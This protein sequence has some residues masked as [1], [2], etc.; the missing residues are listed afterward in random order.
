M[1]KV[2]VYS[3]DPNPY[4][5]A[6]YSNMHDVRYK[7][8]EAPLHSYTLGIILSFPQLILYR[9][10]GYQIFHLHWLYIFNS[11]IPGLLFNNFFIKLFFMIYFVCFL[12]LIK[13]LGYKLIWTAH[14]LAPHE[15]QFLNDTFAY[16]LVAKLA[17]SII[18]HSEQTR[19]EMKRLGFRTDR[20]NIIPVGNY[21]ELY[22]NNV[23]KS[24]ARKFLH[25]NGD[26]FVFL[27]FGLIRDYKGVDSLLEQFQKLSEK[28]DD[29][30]LIIAGPCKDIKMRNSINNYKKQLQQK[31]IV[32]LDYID[33]AEIQYYLNG[34]DV[35]VLPFKKVTTSSTAIL[36]LSFGK[37]IICPRIGSLK[38]IPEDLGFFYSQDDEQGLFK[39]MQSALENKNKLKHIEKNAK[40]YS[41]TFSWKTI[42]EETYELYKKSLKEL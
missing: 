36:A 21:G 17:D 42:G 20:T 11:P 7:Y 30:T 31:L 23:D 38:D 5:N 27:F 41:K 24:E 14:N 34:T 12:L 13:L 32:K 22:P 18:I 37:S 33:D 9:L 3:K 40:K 39:A 15:K 8:L 10:K 29:C 6:L 19:T 35:L 2:L 25:I 16:K 1:I 26:Q 28:R 4:Q